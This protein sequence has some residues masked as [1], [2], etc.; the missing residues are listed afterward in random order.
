[1]GKAKERVRSSGQ[2]DL[3]WVCRGSCKKTRHYSGY[4]LN[5]ARETCVCASCTDA[6]ELK[7]M[8]VE[9]KPFQKG[10]GAVN[11]KERIN[12]ALWFAVC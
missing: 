4:G 12:I 8:K 5:W 3:S 6:D 9:L 1:M 10:E 7:V 2:C 11:K